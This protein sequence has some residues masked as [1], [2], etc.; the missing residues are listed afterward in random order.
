M[1]CNTRITRD[2]RL[3]MLTL[4]TTTA[5]DYDKVAES[6][7]V[8]CVSSRG[9]QKL[10]GRLEKD[11]EVTGFTSKE[12]TEIPQL[13]AHCEK[14]TETGR[15]TACRTFLNRLSQLLNSMTLWASSDGSGANMTAEQRAKEARFLQKGLTELESV[16]PHPLYDI[17]HFVRKGL[18]LT[19]C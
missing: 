3:E 14:L 1:A 5:R 18:H 11:A 6:L 19:R 2:S 12:Q 7:P 13:Q 16:R 17:P 8:F 15:S 4:I 9:Y 10:C